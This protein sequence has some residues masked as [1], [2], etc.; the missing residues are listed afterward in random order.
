[1]LLTGCAK[2]PSEF[3]FNVDSE[4]FEAN[5]HTEIQRDFIVA[6]TADISFDGM[7][8][9]EQSQP[10]PVNISWTIKNDTN[11]K[12]SKYNVLIS[13]NSDLETY[14]TYSTKKTSIDVYNLK[15]ATQYYYRIDAIYSSKTFNSDIY[16]FKVVDE[17]PR[18][19]YVE[20]LNNIRDLGGWKIDD[21]HRVK[22][23]MI[24]RS[25]EFNETGTK[26]CLLNKNSISTL[27]NDLGIKTDVDIRRNDVDSSGSIETGGITS[28][29]LGNDVNYVCYPMIYKGYNVLEHEPNKESI[30]SF[31]NLLADETKYPVIF[32]CAQ[33][34]DRTGCLSFVLNALLGVSRLD[35][36]KDYMFTNFS[37]VGGLCNLNKDVQLKYEATLLT[38][39]RD[40][41]DL[42][43]QERTYAYL[44]EKIGVSN[45]NL[46]KII[47]ILV[48]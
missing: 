34:K 46:D 3:A 28:S 4:L 1:M 24:Y 30:K 36:E 22:Q 20:K 31:F 16:S 48:D 40:N 5:I 38:Y 17:A 25:P 19:I 21:T 37:V 11:S 23:G 43:Y 10:L 14:K 45:E 7:G 32:H 44:N 33:G 29:P 15:V 8:S 2:V 12:P 6:T 26:K 47:D 35:L 13:E 42:T 9:L 18:N 39:K 27:V 41:V